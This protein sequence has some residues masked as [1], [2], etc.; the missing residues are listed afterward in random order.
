[1]RNIL[2]RYTASCL[3]LFTA[4]IPSLSNHAFAAENRCFSETGFCISGRIREY[5]EQNGGLSVFGL[6]IS[7]VAM[8]EIDGQKVI[9][10]RFERNRLELHPTNNRPY[11]VLLGRLGADRLAQANRD[12][13]AF[14][15]TTQQPGCQFFAQTQQSVCGEILAYWRAHGLQIDGKARVTEAE[16]LALFGLPL[17]GVL[18]ETLSDGKEYQV[19]WF[20]RARFELHPENPAP[21]RV[22]LG[23]LGNEI[24]APVT[25]STQDAA[26]AT[27]TVPQ[28]PGRPSSDEL[29]GFKYH[30][31]VGGYW[32]SE[33]HGIIVEVRNFNYFKNPNSLDRNP[34]R[35]VECE[36][37]VINDPKKSGYAMNITDMAFMLVDSKGVANG[38]HQKWLVEET[39]IP[40][41]TQGRFVFLATRGEAPTKL[42]ANFSG[43][44]LDIDLQVW[45]I[46]D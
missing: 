8:M 44:S 9:A 6:P 38:V 20:E 2:T 13:N 18:T 22:L 35:F 4:I 5:W 10:Q 41:R 12:W 11:D 32:R 19:Q 23:L 16:S 39:G 40:H 28:S 31:P 3:L 24:G 26:G 17:S 1:M 15:K 43:L 45:P 29:E 46:P 21:Y 34:T 14:S 42:V 27:V 36:I 7:A 30:M 25:A 37:A 33:N